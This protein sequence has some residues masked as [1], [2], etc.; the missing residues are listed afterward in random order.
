MAVSRTTKA[1]KK[2]AAPKATAVTMR[3]KVTGGERIKTLPVSAPKKL[4]ARK[5]PPTVAHEVKQPLLISVSIDDGPA[6]VARYAGLF[7]M[8]IGACFASYSLSGLYVEM[9]ELST[10][11]Q[12]VTALRHQPAQL[13]TADQP[14]SAPV[15]TTTPLQTPVLQEPVPTTIANGTTTTLTTTQQP[16]E[17]ERLAPLIVEPEVNIA[18]KGGDI[19]QDFVDIGIRVEYAERVEL[20]LIPRTS[21]VERYLGKAFRKE[22]NVWMFTQDTR[23]VP[24]GEYRLFARVVNKYGAYRSGPKELRVYN[25]PK[26]IP[27]PT[28]EDITETTTIRTNID[29][30]SAELEEREPESDIAQEIKTFIAPLPVS[31]PTN[32]GEVPRATSTLSATTTKTDE[33]EEESVEESVDPAID[34]KAERFIDALGAEFKTLLDLYGVALRSDDKEGMKRM[35]E[36]IAEL[37]RQSLDRV[38]TEIVTDDGSTEV[39]QQV[40]DR[41]STLFQVALERREKE[42]RLILD[43][44][45][46]KMKRD[47]DRDGISDYDE[48]SLYKTDPFVADT[49][50]DGFTDGA[51]VLS[52]YDPKNDAREVGVA[53]EDPREEGTLRDDIL[54]V[55][56]LDVLAFAQPETSSEPQD[57][58][59]IFS[60]VALPN[61]FVT[62]YIYSTPVVVTVKTGE[63]GSW[64]YSF[65]KELENGQHEI[66]VGI[67][68][69]AGKLVAK[70]KPFPFVKT[71][72]AY[73]VGRV[74]DQPVAVAV[75]SQ[76]L[77]SE[78]AL[79]L[80]IS[81][82]VMMVGLVLVLIGAHLAKHAKPHLAASVAPLV[83]PAL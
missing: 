43:R 23:Q 9:V 27:P 31:S 5:A 28:T 39:A 33:P 21:L 17:E 71:A 8:L 56:R 7:F 79:V 55:E 69:N 44:V 58:K 16:K 29:S 66:Y 13:I 80:T 18:V 19:L 15:A 1:P 34:A 65:D 48:Q 42:E 46:D 35:L 11:S 6:K 2:K 32:V 54:A 83:S 76:R 4:R 74:S 81:L 3:V 73:S 59:V 52:G 50:A 38:E 45:G 64:N 36:R 62:L 25:R 14:I 82:V 22:P 12:F 61:S 63:D 60:G 70:S 40:K 77:F 37:R 10:S 24:N 68:D 49:D 51:E 72:N 41:M 75:P 26:D 57:Q 67:T 53:F 78:N 20:F 30:A 47:S